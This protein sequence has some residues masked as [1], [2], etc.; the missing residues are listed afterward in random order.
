MQ[1]RR[2]LR[3]PFRRRTTNGVVEKKEQQLE[4]H[5]A[6]L[7]RRSPPPRAIGTEDRRDSH[8]VRIVVV[9]WVVVVGT[10]IAILAPT[11]RLGSGGPLSAYNSPHQRGA[12]SL[13]SPRASSRDH[14]RSFPR[15]CEAFVPVAVSSRVLPTRPLE[16]NWSLRRRRR[17]VFFV[18]V[19][20]RGGS[21]N[22]AA[23]AAR[24][25][26]CRLG[27][28]RTSAG[29]DVTGRRRRRQDVRA[30]RRRRSYGSVR[31]QQA[32]TTRATAIMQSQEEE[33]EEGERERARPTEQHRDGAA[34]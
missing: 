17:S 14:S 15:T 22:V 6:F 27:F 25:G 24:R 33:E 1:Q 7:R 34:T 5:Q 19:F 28:E 23:S 10:L 9:E 29:R 31:R 20:G 26:C 2:R 30:R 32:E 13:K 8:S 11:F 16:R 21:K 4:C 12:S 3:L 18:F